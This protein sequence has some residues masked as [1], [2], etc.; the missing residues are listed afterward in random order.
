M[1]SSFALK[2]DES[3][4]TGCGMCAGSCSYGALAFDGNPSVDESSCRLCGSCAG[5]CPTGALYIPETKGTAV[6]ECSGIWVLAETDG[7]SVADVVFELLGKARELASVTGDHVAAVLVGYGISAFAESLFDGGADRVY[8]ADSPVFKD[9]IEENHAAAVVAMVKE[10]KPS[11]LL[12]CATRKGRGLSAR[13]ASVL[14]TGLTADC[15]SLK[16]DPESGLLL[17]IRPAFGG[18]LMAEIKTPEK[19]PQMASVRPGV[20]KRLETAYRSSERLTVEADISGIVPDPRIRL[21]ETRPDE[22]SAC[23]L[24]GSR[25]IIAVGRGV[26]NPAVLERLKK[27]ADSIGGVIAGSRAAVEAGLVDSSVQIG[28]TGHTVSPDLYIAV[29]ISGQIQHTAAISG[30]R[31]IVAVNPDRNAPIFSIANYGIVGRVEDVMPQLELAC[32]HLHG[33]K[34][35]SEP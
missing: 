10:H 27:W 3:L 26:K 20:M 30:A 2:F 24:E 33:R 4:C 6:Q 28:Q 1:K 12:A 21:L 25:T 32:S 34:S 19:R 13:V 11:V 7:N 35:I 29:G 15:T 23:S 17:Q 22:A 16:I 8:I 5:S 31:C 9:Y 14:E 18:N